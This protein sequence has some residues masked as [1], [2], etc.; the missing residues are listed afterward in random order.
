MKEETA[1][2]EII[3]INPGGE[4]I[5]ISAKIGKPY[6]VEGN[7]GID[8]WAC[9][10]S[11]EPLYK[12]LHDAHGEGSLQALCLAINLI[13]DLLQS[14]IEKGGKLVHEDGTRFSIESYSF[15][16]KENT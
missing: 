9:P 15:G 7:E 8:E 13:L 4:R 10:V 11:L 3:G 12:S 1:K 16:N 5:K 14:F 6:P 2:L